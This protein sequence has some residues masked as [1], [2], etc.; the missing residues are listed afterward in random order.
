MFLKRRFFDLQKSSKAAVILQQVFAHLSLVD[1]KFFGLRFCNNK[2]QTVRKQKHMKTCDSSDV[3][4]RK[5][6]ERDKMEVV[7]PTV[8]PAGSDTLVAHR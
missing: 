1:V 7:V 8:V 2:Q 6:A 5:D 4:S 3:I